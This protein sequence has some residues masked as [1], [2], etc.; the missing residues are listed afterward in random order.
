MNKT[1]LKDA[2]FSGRTLYDLFSFEDGDECEIYKDH[3]WNG[4]ETEDIVYIPCLDEYA[5]APLNEKLDMET[6]NDV[7]DAV[8]TGGE[9]LATCADDQ[10]VAKL[11]LNECWWSNP[12]MVWLDYL[13]CSEPEDLARE[14]NIS[15]ELATEIFK[16]Y[17]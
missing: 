7:V 10:N 4:S 16:D 5:Y 2:L 6:I 11:V 14:A 1:E 15:I 17:E 12:Q 3:S 13:A 9:F 8:W